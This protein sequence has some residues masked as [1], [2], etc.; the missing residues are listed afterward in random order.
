MRLLTIVTGGGENKFQVKAP[1]A[2]ARGSE[3]SGAR[4][5]WV[6][7]VQS[8]ALHGRLHVEKHMFEGA[9]FVETLQALGV[10]FDLVF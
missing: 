5:R 9:R 7:G 3:A 6:R 1:L 4:F 8:L 2:H 10:G